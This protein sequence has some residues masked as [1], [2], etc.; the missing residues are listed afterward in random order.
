MK[1]K[2]TNQQER[3]WADAPALGRSESEVSMFSDSGSEA[4]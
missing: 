2:N 4:P 3:L 1:R